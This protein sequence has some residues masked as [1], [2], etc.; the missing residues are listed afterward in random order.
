[1]LDVG[2]L[3]DLI[4]ARQIGINAAYIYKQLRCFPTGHIN[5]PP[6]V[7]VFFISYLLHLY[8]IILFL[9]SQYKVIWGWRCAGRLLQLFLKKKQPKCFPAQYT[10]PEFIYFPHLLYILYHIFFIQSIE[11]V[12]F[13]MK[14]RAYGL[15]KNVHGGRE[16]WEHMRCC[17]GR[18]SAPG[19]VGD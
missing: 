3:S 6:G 10:Y 18:R 13:L 17:A 19:I 8:Y 4:C 15:I 16:Y 12:F 11:S 9:Y 1:M 5:P 14:V 2:F 7:L